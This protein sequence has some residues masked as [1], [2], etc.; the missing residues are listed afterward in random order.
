TRTWSLRLMVTWAAPTWTA[1]ITREHPGTDQRRLQ[2]DDVAPSTSRCRTYP[3]RYAA[4]SQLIQIAINAIALYVAVLLV[5]GLEFHGE[6]WKFVLVAVAF[7]LVNTY[8]RPILR[9]VTLPISILTLGIFLLIINAFMI[10]LVG[11]VSVQ[12]K[13]GFTVADFG[14]ALLGAIVVAVV[15]FI[16]AVTLSPARFAG[17]MF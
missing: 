6:W 15:G 4:M 10:L 7:S 11:A 9:I 17:R 3:L 12:L 1:S 8:L 13:L 5:R 14:A 2:P 16:L